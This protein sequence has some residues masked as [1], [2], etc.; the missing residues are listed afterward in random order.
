MRAE[1]REEIAKTPILAA[2]AHLNEFK[3]VEPVLTVALRR[4]CG[5][6]STFARRRKWDRPMVYKWIQQLALLSISTRVQ[7][8]SYIE[9]A[10]GKRVQCVGQDTFRARFAFAQ[11]ARRSCVRRGCIRRATTPN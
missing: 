6:R 2:A 4:I 9:K 8:L 5:A 10:Q 1:G 11:I 7:R 3:T